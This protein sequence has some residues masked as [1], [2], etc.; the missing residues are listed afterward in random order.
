MIEAGGSK[1]AE[2]MSLEEGGSVTCPAVIVG[3]LTQPYLANFPPELISLCASGVPTIMTQRLEEGA[4]S[5]CAAAH[6][7]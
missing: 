5:L 3:S 7:C 6:F 2:N 4:I 1:Q